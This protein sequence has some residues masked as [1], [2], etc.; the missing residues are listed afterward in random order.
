MRNH[1]LVPKTRKHLT[2]ATRLVMRL[3]L[4]A[5]AVLGVAAVAPATASAEP[6]AV[7]AQQY[8]SYRAAFS[9]NQALSAGGFFSPTKVIRY[10]LQHGGSDWHKEGTINGFRLH[11][12]LW[13]DNGVDMCLAGS[14]TTVF[15]DFCSSDSATTGQNWQ[16]VTTGGISR[17]WHRGTGLYLTYPASANG[18]VF[19]AKSAAATTQSFIER[20]EG[21][22]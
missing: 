8:F 15:D 17:L 3:A 9:P 11:S 16:L 2:A 18:A 21:I 12:R 13:H 4:A 6:V 1:T 7:T 20:N 14:G 19:L 22:K 10:D 5:L